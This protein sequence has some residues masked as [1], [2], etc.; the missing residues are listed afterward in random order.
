MATDNRTL[1]QKV[2]TTLAQIAAGG[3][4]QEGQV[5][6]F[7]VLAI[8]QPVMMKQVLVTPMKNQT[9]ER[10]KMRFAGR[11]LRR[12]LEATALPL[13]NRSAPTFSL[14]NL[15]SVL[16]RAEVRITDEVLE[17]QIERGAFKD[18]VMTELAKAIGRDMEFVAIQGDVAS[19]DDLLATQNGWVQRATA[20]QVAGGVAQLNQALVRD[21]LTALPDEF[22]DMDKLR[23]YTNIHA[24]IRYNDDVRANRVSSALGDAALEGKWKANYY[25]VPIEGIPEF[26][27]ALGGGLNE[28]VVLLTDPKNLALGFQRKVRL[29]V[30]RDEPAGVTIIVATVR[31]AV[32]IV[33]VAA[34]ARINAV[35]GV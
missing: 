12:G 29:G 13:A 11:V 19:A 14:F 23:Y 24:A 34:A 4:L 18:T 7:I 20:N 27:A 35:L 15:T 9:E 31:F 16:Y 22:T 17:D 28:T 1:L 33:E 26:P 8:N 25:G 32:A 5:D 6:R 2:D 3:L 10:D 21:A 30:Q